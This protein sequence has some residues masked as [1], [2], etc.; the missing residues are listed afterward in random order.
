ML[1]CIGGGCFNNPF[2]LIVQ[3]MIVNFISLSE[4]DLKEVILPL[5]DKRMDYNVFVK[6]LKKYN[7][8]DSL[9]NVIFQS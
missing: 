5:Y 2:E 1:T 6:E 4:S 3:R 7:Y 8:P 9:I